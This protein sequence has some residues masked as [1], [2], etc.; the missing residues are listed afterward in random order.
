VTAARWHA[1]AINL[2][3]QGEWCASQGDW[4]GAYRSFGMATE[5][6]LKSIYLRNNQCA[7]MPPHMRTAASHDLTYVAEQAGLAQ[8]IGRLQGT[9]RS[10]W[11]TVR[12]YNQ[13]KRYPNAAFPSQEGK[14]LK[15][16]LFNPTNGIWQWLLSL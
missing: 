14:D 16:A 9:Q 10:Y 8:A 15:R 6:L 5:H 11:L 12:D 3:K 7:D 13:G 2:K 4:R 1:D